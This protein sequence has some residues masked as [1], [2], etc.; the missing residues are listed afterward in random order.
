MV[1]AVLAALKEYLAIRVKESL[2]PVTDLIYNAQSKEFME[3]FLAEVFGLTPEELALD[4][5]YG[6]DGI[7]TIRLMRSLAIHYPQAIAFAMAII[8]ADILVTKVVATMLSTLVRLST[9]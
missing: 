5:F 7:E 6:P 8:V 2:I 4:S 9:A 1:E 3:E